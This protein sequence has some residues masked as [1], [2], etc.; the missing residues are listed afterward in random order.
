MLSP[1]LLF[2]V[3]IIWIFGVI[4]GS[5][6]NYNN[7]SDT[8]VGSSTAHS[9]QKSG[10]GQLSDMD[11]LLNYSNAVQ[12]VNVLGGIPLPLPN[13]DYFKVMFGVFTLN[14]SFLTS[15][16]YGQLFWLFFLFPFSLMGAYGVI[17]LFISIIRGNISWG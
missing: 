11:Y 10:Y 7:T 8:W 6:Y 5:T 12:H 1:K 13:P 3:A 16:V 14:F 9:Y 4:M 17:Y 2:I 15:N